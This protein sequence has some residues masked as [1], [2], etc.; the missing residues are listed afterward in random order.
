MTAVL[1]LLLA[2]C[3]TASGNTT[4][5][6]APLAEPSTTSTTPSSTT[7][8][9]PTTTTTVEECVERD[10]VL[11]NPRGFVC[12]PHL[13]TIELTGGG[14]ASPETSIHLPGTYTTRLFDPGFTFTNTNQF[15]S[16]GEL[17]TTAQLDTCDGYNCPPLLIAWSGTAARW[18]RDLPLEDLE[19]VT[20]LDRS[21]TQVGGY[22]AEVADFQGRD[23][24]V[25]SATPCYVLTIPEAPGAAQWAYPPDGRFVII[26]VDT[27]AGLVVFDVEVQAS[28][29][30]TYWTEVAQPILDSIE[31][32]DP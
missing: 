4:T 26:S 7:T 18:F 14:N 1:V 13:R 31:F 17:P 23:C 19:F 27:P 6:T 9:E 15:A 30:D 20:N 8:E 21:E 2:A 5:T 28:N 22:P 32:L 12:P 29:F 25:E 10:A 11:R 3:S 24:E 16:A